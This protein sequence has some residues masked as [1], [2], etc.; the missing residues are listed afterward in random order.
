MTDEINKKKRQKTF[1]YSNDVLTYDDNR[2]P[3]FALI[4]G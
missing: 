1:G 3:S 4:M 2:L